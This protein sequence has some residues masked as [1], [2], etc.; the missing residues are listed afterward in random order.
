MLSSFIGSAL[1]AALILSFIWWIV[2]LRADNARRGAYK[3]QLDDRNDAID[4]QYQR[5][6]DK[7]NRGN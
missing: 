7:F 2:A 6:L 4:V 1:L 5:N 3:Q